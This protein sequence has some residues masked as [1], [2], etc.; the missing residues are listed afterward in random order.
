MREKGDLIAYTKAHIHVRAYITYTMTLTLLEAR[1]EQWEKQLTIGGV[2]T[3]TPSSV[4]VQS[5][6]RRLF[7]SNYS[8]LAQCLYHLQKLDKIEIEHIKVL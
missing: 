8:C 1:I 3:R 4:H 7:V 6:F 5:T 2:Y